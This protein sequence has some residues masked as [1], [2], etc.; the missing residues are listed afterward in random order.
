[1]TQGTDK[2]TGS[3]SSVG[4]M[5]QGDASD[6]QVGEDPSGEASSQDSMSSSERELAHCRKLGST[7]RADPATDGVG[8]T[9]DAPEGLANARDGGKHNYPGPVRLGWDDVTYCAAPV[10][11]TCG[12]LFGCQLALVTEKGMQMH[13]SR[14]PSCQVALN[15]RSRAACVATSSSAQGYGSHLRRGCARSTR[16]GKKGS[17]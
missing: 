16:L 6:R 12:G 14:N 13:F 10:K 11:C 1:M 5:S 8:R 2:D 3:G 17:C 15:E 9:D 4:G 7:A